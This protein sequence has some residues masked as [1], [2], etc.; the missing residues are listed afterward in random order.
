MSGLS[1]ALRCLYPPRSPDPGKEA[2]TQI[3]TTVRTSP[4]A[5]PRRL[6]GFQVNPDAALERRDDPAIGSNADPLDIGLLTH[7]RRGLFDVAPLYGIAQ[8]AIL[9]ALVLTYAVNILVCSAMGS[10]RRSAAHARART[11]HFSSHRARAPRSADIRPKI[12]PRSR[13]AAATGLL[14]DFSGG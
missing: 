7:V 8:R 5:F 10:A 2:A 4:T 11:S 3:S 13:H 14:T 1:S 6:G 12:S 9:P